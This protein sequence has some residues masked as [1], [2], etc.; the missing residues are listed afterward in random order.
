MP[1]VPRANGCY[2]AANRTAEE[3]YSLGVTLNPYYPKGG[4]E[5]QREDT[6][7]KRVDG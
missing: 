5:Q 3:P 6:K 2:D 1:A 7:R 4:F